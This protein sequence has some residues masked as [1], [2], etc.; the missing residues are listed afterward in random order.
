LTVTK[1]KLTVSVGIKTYNPWTLN[2]KPESGEGFESAFVY[3]IA[4]N[5]GYKNEDVIWIR[6]SFDEMIQPGKKKYDIAIDQFSITEERKIYVDFSESYY[7]VNQAIVTTKDSNIDINNIQLKNL[8]FGADGINNFGIDTVNNI[9]KPTNKIKL[10]NNQDGVVAALNKKEINAL[11]C[12]FPTA[13]YLSNVVIKNGIILGQI[14]IK[15]KEN[16]G[17]VLQKN[18]KITKFI[19]RA[20][21]NL[22][23]NGTLKQIEEKWLRT[24]I[25][26]PLL[27]IT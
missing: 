21:E 4:N 6:N 2:N 8:M 19:N 9:I 11:I 17:L 18:S 3:A 20:I 22:K 5:L 14:D 27:K 12:D 13:I 7:T 25:D 15:N 23:S 24:S 10:Y 16:F 1:N 26:V